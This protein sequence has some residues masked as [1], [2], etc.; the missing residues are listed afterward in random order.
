MLLLPAALKNNAMTV[1][2]LIA[3]SISSGPSTSM[4][5]APVVVTAWSKRYRCV[6][7]MITSGRG[8]GRLGSCLIFSGSIPVMEAA[9]LSRMAQEAPEV[10]MADSLCSILAILASALSCNL[11]IS[12]KSCEV[13]LIAANTSGSMSD[14]DKKV[15]VT[16][17]LMT[18]VP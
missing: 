9:V 13:E 2:S 11:Y 17:A 7:C 1:L 8:P 16:D 12:A 4:I 5:L 3:F 10:T 6:F 14:P 15:M 18:G